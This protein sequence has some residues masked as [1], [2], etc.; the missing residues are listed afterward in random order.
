MATPVGDFFRLDA[1][2]A[3]LPNRS[4]FAYSTSGS[5][6]CKAVCYNRNLIL[7][8]TAGDNDRIMSMKLIFLTAPSGLSLDPVGNLFHVSVVW[9]IA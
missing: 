8:A 9:H 4:P 3:G 2:A 5:P 7:D 1:V 6:A